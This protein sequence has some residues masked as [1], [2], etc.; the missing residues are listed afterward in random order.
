MVMIITVMYLYAC[1]KPRNRT[2]LSLPYEYVYA[3]LNTE[4]GMKYETNIPCDPTH[5]KACGH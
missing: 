2:N 3:Y 1:Q 4:S 5:Y